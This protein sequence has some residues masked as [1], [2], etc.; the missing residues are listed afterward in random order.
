MEGNFPEANIE[1]I[2]FDVL[3]EDEIPSG[4]Y[5]TFSIK[6]FYKKDEN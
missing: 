3:R 6:D 1:D 4:E 2:R 5:G